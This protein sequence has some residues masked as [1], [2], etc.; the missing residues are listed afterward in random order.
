MSRGYSTADAK[1]REPI[2]I[3]KEGWLFPKIVRR[4]EA[5]RYKVPVKFKYHEA[6]PSQL[7]EIDAAIVKA[8]RNKLELFPLVGDEAPTPGFLYP[9]TGRPNRFFQ[10]FER[11]IVESFPDDADAREYVREYRRLY[12]RNQIVFVT[13]KRLFTALSLIIAGAAF[14]KA[15]SVNDLWTWA[16]L[17]YSWLLASLGVFGIGHASLINFY[18]ES[19]DNS[20][21]HVSNVVQR[22]LADLRELFDTVLND[23]DRGFPHIG[24]DPDAWNI[25][26]KFLMRFTLFVGRRVEYLERFMQVEMWRVRRIRHWTLLYGVVLLLCVVGAYSFFGGLAEQLAS[27]ATESSWQSNSTRIVAFAHLA[28]VV[29]LASLSMRWGRVTVT[30]ARD[31]MQPDGWKR[32]ADI[33]LDE[34]VGSQVGRDK[35]LI[36]Q[37]NQENVFVGPKP[38]D[39]LGMSQTVPFS[40]NHKTSRMP[41]Q[42]L[43]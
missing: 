32:F 36:A 2:A 40:A 6:K 27:I 5:E 41:E 15:A 14:G 10:I 28:Y 34:Q 31:A 38:K 22:R 25:Q 4:P 19:F 21:S 42:L 35:K 20:S 1:E 3:S 23:I 33:E 13:L 37:H 7:E 29:V 24:R 43:R 26:A 18:R 17:H 9:F 30:A 11:Y 8:F 12:W 16:Q 39:G